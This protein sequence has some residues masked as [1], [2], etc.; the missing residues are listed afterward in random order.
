MA[1]T[2]YTIDNCKYRIDQLEKVVYMIGKSSIGSINTT[3]YYIDGG[4]GALKI[5]CN[6]ISINEESSLDERYR[7]THTLNFE[8]DGYKTIEDLDDKFYAVVRDKNGDYYLV[9]PQFKMRIGYTYTISTSESTAFEMRTESDYPLMKIIN[10]APWAESGGKNPDGSMWKWVTIT[11]TEDSNTYICD[12]PS[13]AETLWECKD[14]SLCKIDEIRINE[15]AYSTFADG[16][17]NYTNDGFKTI[18]FIKNSA[19]FV[20]Q[21]DGNNVQHKLT[22]TIP[23]D[24]TNWHN[25]LLDFQTNKY[26]TI[27]T[28][29]CGKSIACGFQHGLQPSYV[30]DGSSS[31]Q[32]QIQVTLQDL[33]D[34]G[35]LIQV[36]ETIDTSGQT[37]TTWHFVEQY[38]ECV[39]NNNAKYLLMEE[40]DMFGNPM[41]L[42]EC[43]E[44]YREDFEWLAA[45]DKLIGEFEDSPSIYF[46]SSGACLNTECGI[47]TNL[48]DMTFYTKST[49]YFTLICN[50]TDW[51]IDTSSSGITVSPSS[52]E[53]GVEY[54]I[55]VTN[56]IT[57]ISA[58][59]TQYITVYSC[60][61]AET[62][63]TITI[64]ERPL[65]DC[66]PQ[67]DN[68]SASTVNQTVIIPSNA[69]VRSVVSNSEWVNN[70][71]VQDGY[72]RVNVNASLECSARTATL[73]ATM[74]DSTN[75]NPHI[76]ELYITQQG[77]DCSSI[78]WT[79]HYLSGETYQVP[80]TVNKTIDASQVSYTS[81]PLPNTMSSCTIGS[82]TEIINAY[83]FVQCS[84]LSEVTVDRATP[85]TI[86]E[87]VFPNNVQHIYVDCAYVTSYK[88]AW[89]DYASK[90]E[91]IAGTCPQYNRTISGTPYC[92]GL[93]KYV[94]VYYQ[95]SEDAG[96]TWSTVTTTT[97]L[98]ETNSTDCGYVPPQ[99]INY[100]T[101]PL[102]LTAIDT[103]TFKFIGSTLDNLYAMKYSLDS[104]TTWVTMTVSQVPM[105][106]ANQKVMFKG[107]AV[108][109]FL[110]GIG[111][112]ESSGRFSVEGNIMSL[113]FGDNFATQT[114]LSGKDN[115][116]LNLFMNCAGLISA[117]NLKL[118][119]TTLSSF[120]YSGTFYK[121]VNLTTAPELPAT[122]LVSSCYNSM[123]NTCSSLTYIKCLATDISASDCT[124]AW[125]TGVSAT[126]T[127]VKASSMSNWGSGNNGIP[128]GWNIENV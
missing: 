85:P 111:R 54:T 18:D 59:N 103:C 10:F 118:P 106:Q 124:T 4:A 108:P 83:A 21:F 28:T 92:Q 43:L 90:I 72:V 104:G 52:G 65:I 64:V 55:G 77:N 71:Q 25:I 99:P 122:T 8:V 58:A 37:A 126:G 32:N 120:C 95:V 22:F 42:Y 19:S 110:Y 62:E 125:V 47:S 117:E 88:E 26:C 12:V 51:E 119:A 33:H 101:Q 23:Y 13:S 67:G 70:I 9:N 38:F 6:S 56:N 105:V 76:H 49:K 102:T 109:Q 80:C 94:D 61:S 81:A 14:Y 16:F 63:Y 44:G 3:D 68:Y 128:S 57:P 113:I 11:P 87:Q 86:G 7:F 5:L 50:N 24:E 39:D 121:C 48:S 29:T 91:A 17:A 53:A 60:E 66:F 127:F 112:F 75:D 36:N 96:S 30:L 107:T 69:C 35:K 15:T 41:D 97:V 1:V 84:S 74:C 98:V 40:Y 31:E 20:E 114:S 2:N 27:I 115:A 45:E 89:S 116:F 34:Q 93:D 46:A 100:N 82:C 123:F 78:M 79:G 73:T